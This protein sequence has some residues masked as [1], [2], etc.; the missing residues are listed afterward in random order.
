MFFT[1]F[2]FNQGVIGNV[3]SFGTIGSKVVKCQEK[4]VA[5]FRQAQAPSAGA[6]R[7]ARVFKRFSSYDTVST[8]RPFDLSTSSRCCKLRMLQ[9]QG[10]QM[11]A[12]D[13]DCSR[14]CATLLP[15]KITPL[16]NQKK[17]ERAAKPN[18]IYALSR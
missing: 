4:K 5:P 9:A 17:R 12:G 8:L 1:L 13:P 3:T 16:N 14:D 2:F 10:R 11:R 18:R 7:A 6:S 15:I